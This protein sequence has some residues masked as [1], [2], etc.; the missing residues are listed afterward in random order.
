MRVVVFGATGTIGTALVPA[1]AREHDVLVLL[2][3]GRSNPEIAAEL[4]VSIVSWPNSWSPHAIRL[5]TYFIT[6]SF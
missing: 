3:R 1:L 4:T 2:A 5:S 6:V